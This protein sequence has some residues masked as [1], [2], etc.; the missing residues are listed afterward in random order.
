MK[1]RKDKQSPDSKSGKHMF[2]RSPTEELLLA[3]IKI[4]HLNK[5]SHIC[6]HLGCET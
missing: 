5:G 2:A 1:L 4:A 3:H 6:C